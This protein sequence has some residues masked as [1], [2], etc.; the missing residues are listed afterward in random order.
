MAMKTCTACRKPKLISHFT[1]RD[2]VCT[3]CREKI[4]AKAAAANR[5]KALSIPG[6]DVTSTA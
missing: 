2:K 4:I 5:G 6:D 1:I 3:V